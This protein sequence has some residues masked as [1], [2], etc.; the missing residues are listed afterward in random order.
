[1]DG[2]HNCYDATSAE[3]WERLAANIPR[4][5][6][7]FTADLGQRMIAEL[8]HANLDLADPFLEDEELRWIREPLR[9]AL[10][11]TNVLLMSRHQ[12]NSVQV[13][14]RDLTG[15]DYAILDELDHSFFNGMHTP[16]EII[17]FVELA[18]PTGEDRMVFLGHLAI[19]CEKYLYLCKPDAF[20]AV[21]EKW[22][23][24]LH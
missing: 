23:A 2:K 16:E 20:R 21:R 10:A 8:N 22:S 6:G 24:L 4:L 9:A 5:N 19:F 11:F 17:V 14:L 7:D 1:M 12:Q 18:M 13:D 15:G 3:L